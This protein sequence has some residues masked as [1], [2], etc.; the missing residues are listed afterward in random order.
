MHK[1][2]RSTTLLLLVIGACAPQPRAHTPAPPAIDHA[3]VLALLQLMQY[4]DTRSF[5]Q[6][7]FDALTLNAPALI[8][9]RVMLAA[10]R[11]GDRAAEPL[12]LR[13]L[14][15]T[16]DSV[17]A[18]AAF[19]LG[20]L[21]DSSVNVVYALGTLSRGN[22]EGAAE[23]LHALG[24]IG[25]S[26]ARTSVEDALRTR[27]PGPELREAILAIWHFPRQPSTSVLVRP[28]TTSPDPEIRWRA[29]Y[30]L[31]RGGSDPANV[32]G[33][34]QWMRDP[35]ALVRSFATRGLRAAAADTAQQRPA[36][37]AALLAA[38][39]DP[40]AHVRINAV[41]V[42]ASFRDASHAS[43]VAALLQDPDLNVRVAAVQTLGVIRGGSAAD[44]LDAAAHN[45]A[46]RPSIRGVALAALMGA[47]PVRGL[48]AANE[49]AA[50]S[51]YLLRIY[52]ARALGGV[53]TAESI[54][55]LRRMASDTDPRVVGPAVASTA[56]I[57]GDTL[58]SA[59][60]L[61]IEKLA[62]ADP[63]VRAEALGG[64]ARLTR[65]GDE[66][67]IFD[68]F[69]RA[70]KD[71]TEEAAN[72]AIAV[73]AK[74]AINSSAIVRTFET[75]FPLERIPLPDVRRAAIRQLKVAGSCCKIEPDPGRYA[76]AMDLEVAALRGGVLPRVRV[77][78]A[79]GSF[80]IDLLAADAPLTVL[81]FI[82][83][84]ERKYFDGSRWHRVVPNFVLQDGDPTGTGSGGPGYAIRD[85][86]NRV[87]YLSGAV[88]M[89]LSGPDT[90]GS[91]F[92]VTHSPQ[93]HLDGGYTVFGRV[94]SGMEVANR[95]LQDDPIISMQVIR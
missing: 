22:G 13:G 47:D 20:E 57:A 52:A 39:K 56:A 17:R 40:D 5:D 91:Q 16:T 74:L 18:H 67:M 19:A 72:A 50:S 15:D 94:I 2:I 69:D 32:P 66:A 59:R 26:L 37:A 89:A 55:L 80:E 49:F 81:N 64:L 28:F 46:E 83:L 48:V 6:A 12:L 77:N 3:Q 25:G 87:R 34:V 61:F 92:F 73:L 78:T 10:G 42:L 85:E 93:P 30:A 33:F 75:R 11:I 41:Q 76:K 62:A 1:R 63:F 23:A 21:G 7:K 88:G 54:A 45:Q 29:V 70:L 31:T 38:L 82:T 60:A 95:V 35:D 65:P 68:A 14:A 44:A 71:A 9:A 36:A 53:R 51:D 4:E 58:E 90:G 24:K 27:R 8:R 79:G 43:S 86:I 84:V